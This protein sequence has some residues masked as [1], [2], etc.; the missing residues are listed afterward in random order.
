[1]NHTHA[2]QVITAVLAHLMRLHVLQALTNQRSTLFRSMHAFRARQ[3]STAPM[4]ECLNQLTS[5]MVDSIAV[6]IYRFAKIR[7]VAP[8]KGLVLALV[9]QTPKQQIVP[10]ATNVLLEQKLQK[11]AKQAST[12]TSLGLLYARCARL[13]TGVHPILR[14]LLNAVKVT[15]VQ[16]ELPTKLNAQK[17]RSIR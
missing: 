6:L 15:I 14:P 2:L 10:R 11:Y 7:M 1:M 8:T 17:A 5:A 12:A 4:K 9:F 13:A 16:R 3:V